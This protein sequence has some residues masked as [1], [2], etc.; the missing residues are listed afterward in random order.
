MK[1]PI[2]RLA[3]LFACLVG[4]ST[5]GCQNLFSSDS[6]D[7]KDPKAIYD[8][9]NDSCWLCGSGE[10]YDTG[11]H[12]CRE[13]GKNGCWADEYFNP[14]TRRCV[15]CDD[16][17]INVDTGECI[18]ADNGGSSGS[19]GQG[20]EGGAAG[21]NNAGAGGGAEGGMGGTS[22]AGGMGG[23][24][25]AGGMGGTSMAGGIGGTSMTGGMGGT[26][27]T[28]GT[29]MTGGAGGT[30]MTGGTGGTPVPVDTYPCP[31]VGNCRVLTLGDGVA[32]GVGYTGGY[33]VQLMASLSATYRIE[34]VGSQSAGT[35]AANRPHEGF[36]E[37]QTAAGGGKMGLVDRLPAV[38][39]TAKPHIVI[40]NIGSEDIFNNFQLTAFQTRLKAIID[41]I[42]EGAPNA[43]IVV[44]H[45]PP[46]RDNTFNTRLTGV[47]TAIAN[48]VNTRRV[49]QRITRAAI[50]R[51]FER[52]F[53]PGSVDDAKASATRYY[54]T[55][56]GYDTIADTYA[57]LLRP[58]L[59]LK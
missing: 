34:M 43:L 6:P 31:M 38:V 39:S 3:F 14:D 22:M 42:F 45:P 53:Q 37:Y 13:V 19:A 41:K 24:S 20:A 49:T 4:L 52:P 25:M 9:F 15:F 11:K 59:K 12:T 26:S 50:R 29:A 33:R 18:V 55:R 44:S 56:E 51:T 30:A 35:S 27:M 36:P 17:P 48:E 2:S 1:Y 54:P 58:Q 57:G 8:S 28:G 32:S 16:A 21:N 5:V 47:D 10:M 7:C 40:L 23:T 46:S